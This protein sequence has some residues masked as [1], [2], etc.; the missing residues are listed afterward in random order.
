MLTDAGKLAWLSKRKKNFCYL[1]DR[2]QGVSGVIKKKRGLGVWLRCGISTPHEW[3]SGVL[4]STQ[5]KDKLW[6][7]TE[8]DKITEAWFLL[9]CHNHCAYTKLRGERRGPRR[10]NVGTLCTWLC[11]KLTKE[12]E[13]GNK[14]EST[15]TMI[16]RLDIFSSDIWRNWSWLCL[17]LEW[18]TVRYLGMVSLEKSMVQHIRY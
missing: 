13:R 15:Q 5:T 4:S 3:H 1:C 8:P 16:K 7:Q 6:R 18:C 2:G 17:R 9:R 14:K 11:V 10:N 12:T